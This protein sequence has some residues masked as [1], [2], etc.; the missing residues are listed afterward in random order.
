MISV[1]L[2]EDHTIVRQGL[3]MV[4]EAQSEITVVGE[5]DDGLKVADECAQSKP[6]V[7]LLDLG[8]P[9]LHGLEIIRQVS[10]RCPTTRIVVLSM[11]AR[12]EYVLGALANGAAGYLV[13]GCDAKE[14]VAAIRTVA[15]G[16]RHVSA[17]VATGMLGD[18][19][20]RRHTAPA[21][22]AYETLTEREREVLHLMAEG[23]ANAQIGERLFIS[24]R[25]VETHR[26]NVMRK[27]HLRNQTEIV[28]YAIR[29][30]ILPPD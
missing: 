26:A 19:L 13:K 4:L 1:L 30:G 16:G 21:N 17:D 6:D 9:G 11:H 23:H 3:R 27:L 24:C 12:E 7:L 8:L 14:L 15:S 29:R 22:D 2:A 25:T 10:R 28:R 18:A 5:L 20:D